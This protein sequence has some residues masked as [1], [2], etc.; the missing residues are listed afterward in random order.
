MVKDLLFS[1]SQ[2]W[3][4]LSNF[5]VDAWEEHRAVTAVIGVVL[6]GAVFFCIRQD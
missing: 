3:H 1:L 5:A 6:L 4:L 2:V